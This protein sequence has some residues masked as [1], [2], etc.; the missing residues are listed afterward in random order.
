ML[1]S[2]GPI[3]PR[4]P[5]PNV[6]S[7]ILSSSHMRNMSAATNPPVKGGKLL[8]AINAH[9]A[10]LKALLKLRNKNLH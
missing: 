4:V 9:T 2:K 1:E 5:V 7:D 6:A 10:S 3:A 8:N